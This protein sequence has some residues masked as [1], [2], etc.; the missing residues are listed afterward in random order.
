[1]DALLALNPAKPQICHLLQSKLMPA[2]YHMM[3][4]IGHSLTKS[5]RVQGTNAGMVGRCPSELRAPW[6]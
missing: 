6:F 3:V 2:L 4:I 1:M 5:T